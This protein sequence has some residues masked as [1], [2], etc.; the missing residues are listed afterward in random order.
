MI[1]ESNPLVKFCEQFGI[2]VEQ[3]DWDTKD[4]LKANPW[5]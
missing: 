3:G 5:H 1:M 4:C 2:T